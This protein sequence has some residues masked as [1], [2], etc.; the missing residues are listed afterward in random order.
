M[1][2]SFANSIPSR[3]YIGLSLV[4]G[5]IFMF[6]VD[7]LSL[8]FSTATRG[9][10]RFTILPL[11]VVVLKA[12]ISHLHGCLLQVQDACPTTTESLPPWG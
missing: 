10:T 5:F 8:Y 7:Q 12:D 6:V 1:A 4:V 2:V 9:K 11:F 3:F